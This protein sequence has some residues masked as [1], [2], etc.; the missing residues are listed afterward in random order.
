MVFRRLAY[1]EHPFGRPTLG[2]RKTVERLTSDDCREFYRKVFVPNNLI[3]AIVG[4]FNS[5]KVVEGL[6]RYTA[7]WQKT[8]L[9]EPN[10]PEVKKPDKFIEQIVTMPEAAQAH[11]YMGHAGI[12]RDNPDYYKLLV[13]DYVL[14]TGPGFTDRLSS[15]LRDR[16][17]LAYTVSASITNSAAEEP[18]LFSCY[19]NPA[20][21]ALP[22]VKQ[23]F[24][25]ELAR[26]RKEKPADAEV[27]DAKKFL[28]GNLPFQLITNDRIASVLLTAERYQLGFNYLDDY[29]KAV[30]S[31]TADQVY[32]VAQKYLDPEHM[33]L[34]ISGAVDAT[35]K[36]LALPAPAPKK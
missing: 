36:P 4:D 24:L 29:R 8:P 32:E 12:R 1:G 34:V 16:E 25:Q 22:R 27:E 15:L 31:G 20:P 13:M 26:I 19:A 7:E 10:M 23:L 30:S 3:V 18:G 21:P 5:K 11:V 14:G 17:G 33:I 6:T 2:T 35:G 9:P 28:L